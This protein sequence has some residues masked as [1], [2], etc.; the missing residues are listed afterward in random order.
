M[1]LPLATIQH[2]LLEKNYIEPSDI[3]AAKAYME[4]YDAGLL[5]YLFANQ[6][7][8][9]ELLGQ[10]M[11]EHFGVSYVSLQQKKI[12]EEVLSLIPETVARSKGV[13]AYAR[14]TDHV[15][16][17]MT[18]PNDLQTRH[19]I[20]KRVGM[21][22][23]IHFMTDEDHEILLSHYQIAIG[24]AFNE[25]LRN[26][27]DEDLSRDQRDETI[28]HILDLIFEYGYRNKVSD[29][30]LAAYE[31]HVTVRFRIDGILH[32]MFDMP[33]FVAGLVI[34]R[35]KILSKLAIDEHRRAQ[36]GKLRYRIE[37]DQVD[38]RVSVVPVTQ[39]ENVVMRLLSTKNRSLHLTDL[40]LAHR[41]RKV[42][43]EVVNDPHGMILV[44]GPTGSGKSTTL[45]ALLK[46]LNTREVHIATIEDPVEYNIE[47]VSQIQV[48]PKA[49][50]TFAH[51]LRAI[52]RQDPD[53]IMVGEIRDAETAGIAVNSALTGHLV[54]STLHTNDAATTLPRLLDMDIEAFLV[55]STVNVVVAQRLVRK[56]CQSCRVSYHPNDEEKQLIKN[57]KEINHFFLRKRNAKMS[58]LRLYRGPGCRV[59]HGTGFAD[60]IG[61][62]EI[63]EMDEHM[64]HLI[65]TQQS[66]DEI[67]AYAREQGMT[68]MFEDGLMKVLN[69]VTTLD[70]VLRVTK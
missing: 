14:H 48:N 39:G 17:A 57:H 11:A 44:T 27:D 9:N 30:H 19:L 23:R 13:I 64:R 56:I 68:T 8:T 41:D 53:I 52:V 62:F 33:R 15:D 22:V 32:D 3:T 35:I 26:L 67:K 25:L 2:I 47:G 12:D 46:I 59:C 21:P 28:V 40:G 61:V 43:E 1:S 38:V 42:I 18:N 16:I 58:T 36:D 45:Y 34:S 29:I 20:E 49:Q 70:E 6:L 65:L 7:L 24:D 10:A 63:L 66:S 37:D 60:R 31:K 50:L 69:G 54:L 51:G 55:A 5:D 4:E